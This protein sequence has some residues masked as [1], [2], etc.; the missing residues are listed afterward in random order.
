[1][2]ALAYLI[3]QVNLGLCVNTTELEPNIFFHLYISFVTMIGSPRKRSVW[4]LV[5]LVAR[6]FEFGASQTLTHIKDLRTQL[7]YTN[8]YDFRMRP[9]DDQTQPIGK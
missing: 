1:M 2:D 3:S 5:F 8:S 9:I 7:F 4:F 6:M